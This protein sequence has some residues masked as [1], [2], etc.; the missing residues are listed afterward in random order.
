[1]A[2]TIAS[3]HHP[4]SLR[5]GLAE[6]YDRL[7]NSSHQSLYQL[8]QLLL[9]FVDV[10]MQLPLCQ[11]SLPTYRKCSKNP[12]LFMDFYWLVVRL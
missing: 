10:R 12:C 7:M 3:T 9:N 5:A 6:W 2:E 11:T 1:V 4:H 8:G